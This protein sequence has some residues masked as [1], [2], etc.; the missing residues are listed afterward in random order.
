MYVMRVF[1]D[2]GKVLGFL[3]RFDPEAHEDGKPYPTG[4]AVFTYELA[5]AMKF[6]SLSEGLAYHKQ[7]SLTC[8]LRPDGKPNRP[9]TQFTIQMA[10]VNA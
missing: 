1:D 3:H 9:L 10:K 2:K 7:T 8:P 6:K 4:F 5:K